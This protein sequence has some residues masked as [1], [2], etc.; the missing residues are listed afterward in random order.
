[1]LLHPLKCYSSHPQHAKL[2]NGVHSTYFTIVLLK[3]FVPFR[4]F[5]IF[6]AFINSPRS[7]LFDFAFWT[8]RQNNLKCQTENVLVQNDK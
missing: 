1:M 4:C 6:I 8:K 2:L 5:S 3:V 7:T